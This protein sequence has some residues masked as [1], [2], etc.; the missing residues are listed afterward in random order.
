M[1]LGYATVTTASPLTIT[2]D[3]AA[4][5]IPATALNGYSPAANTRVVIDWVG[6]VVYV[7]GAA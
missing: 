4:T 3:G 7:F 1:A 5:A 6:R 2:Q